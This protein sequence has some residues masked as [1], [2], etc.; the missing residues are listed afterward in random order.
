MTLSSAAGI[1]HLDPSLDGLSLLKGHKVALEGFGKK[2][3][4]KVKSWRS[5]EVLMSLK[6]PSWEALSELSDEIRAN[7]DMVIVLSEGLIEAVFRAAVSLFPASRSESTSLSVIGSSVSNDTLN[8]L[9]SKV[10]N[11]RVSLF[12]AFHGEPSERIL[13]CFERLYEQLARGRQKEEVQ[14]RVFVAGD[15]TWLD[16]AKKQGFRGLTFPDRCAGRYLF[17]SEPVGLALMLSGV[18]AWRCV[19][20]ARSLVRGFDKK[21]G[22]ADQILAYSALREIQL[23]DRCRESLLIPDESFLNFSRWWRLLSE[24]SRQEFAEDQGESRVQV[25]SVLRERDPEKGRQWL[26]EIVLESSQTP[27]AP[28]TPSKQASLSWPKSVRAWGGAEPLLGPFVKPTDP[29]YNQ[30]HVRLLLRRLDPMTIGALFAFFEGVISASHKLAD[31][32]DAWDL[33]QARTSTSLI[34]S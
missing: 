1:L 14:R 8:S 15:N 29:G 4:E 28:S 2:L 22:T 21:A 23:A 27:P 18:P 30:P 16:W 11:Q 13:W 20:G 6:L 19:E 24:D 17:F 31:L 10:E 32:D 25:G 9:L 12:L 33:L 34:E 3:D 7:N 5:L 26:T